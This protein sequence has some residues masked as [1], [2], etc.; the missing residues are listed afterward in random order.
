MSTPAGE[1]S[2]RRVLQASA[3]AAPAI[4]IATSVPAAAASQ[5]TIGANFVQIS[6][7][8]L[9]NHNSAG[10]AAYNFDYFYQVYNDNAA[11]E[12]TE[13]F[14]YQAASDPAFATWATTWLFEIL[15]ATGKVVH[16]ASGNAVLPHGQAFRMPEQVVALPAIGNYSARLTVTSN[17]VATMNGYS[18]AARTATRTTELVAVN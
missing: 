1:I 13:L 6:N 8:Q 12:G 5:P 16:S 7:V 10:A 14:A 2:R 9:V 17:Y 11:F 4:L 15:D 3:W 18:F